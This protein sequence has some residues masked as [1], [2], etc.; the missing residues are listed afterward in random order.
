[1]AR[2]SHTN[3]GEQGEDVACR[4]LQRRGY[5]IL[6]RRFR[7]RYGEI[8]IVAREGPTLV[9]VEVKTR[10]SPAFGSPAEAVTP[11]KQAKI[12]LMAAEFL[13]R[14]WA[15]PI[16]CRFDV[17]AVGAAEGQA[18]KVELIRGAFDAVAFRR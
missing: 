16:P 2:L 8:D 7:T 3:L 13:L 18:P 4:E 1:M 10:S 5:A 11:R 12:S 15:G 14:H 9:F 6:A 17:V